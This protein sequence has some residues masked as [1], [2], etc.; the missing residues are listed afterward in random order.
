MSYST[1]NSQRNIIEQFTIAGLNLSL[2]SLLANT[3]DVTAFVLS[4][5][6]TI[7]GNVYDNYLRGYA[8]NDVIY[9]GGGNDVFLPGLRSSQA[10]I[11]RIDGGAGSDTLSLADVLLNPVTIDLPT[12]L[13]AHTVQTANFISV[14][15]TLVS[16]ENVIGSHA[17][18]IIKGNAAANRLDGYLG[19]DWINGYAGDDI[20]GGGDGHDALLGGLG[21]DALY[22]SFGNDILR[23]EQGGDLLDG[24]AG[25]DTADYRGSSALVDVNLASGLG[26]GGDAA[27][28]RLSNFENLY[29]SAHS[30]ILTGSS[31]VNGVWS[32]AG[33]DRVYGLDGDDLLAGEAGDDTVFGG[34]GND[35]ADGG[36]G[37]DGL[38]GDAGNDALFGGGGNDVIF[39]DAGNDQMLGGAGD[40]FIV[41][42]LG[43]D[44]VALGAGRGLVRFDY[45]NGKDTV[46]DFKSG[47]DR[48]DFTHTDLTLAAIRANAVETAAGVLMTLGSGTILPSGLHLTDVNWNSDMLTA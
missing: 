48:L 28:D 40:D 31:G 14:H 44:G 34:A 13:A 11:D 43:D 33:N 36:L 2:S 30:D 38:F 12:G 22:V 32:G 7:Y 46:F 25:L 17:N 29:G 6:D 15:A 21:N 9:G 26:Y 23:G 1:G 10:G 42:G 4:G 47:E 18:D 39:G 35:K 37:N 20:I 24:G 16:I 8:G 19:N 27:G 5:N 45:G 3:A 41:L